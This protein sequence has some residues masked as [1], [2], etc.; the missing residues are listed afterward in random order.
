[1]L[2]MG[3][4]NKYVVLNSI[5]SVLYGKKGKLDSGLMVQLTL[6]VQ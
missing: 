2:E 5:S 1:M 4:Y 6:F 3:L